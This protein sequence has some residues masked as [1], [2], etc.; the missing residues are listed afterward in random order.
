MIWMF[1]SL[2][3]SALKTGMQASADQRM[4]GIQ[5]DAIKAYNKQVV[6]ASAKSLNEINI[7]RSVSRQQTGQALDG[8]RRQAQQDKAQ[9][10]LQAAASDTMGASVDANIRDVDVQL[11]QAEST[12][13]R[14]QSLQEL[15][16]NSAVQQ[17]TD[18]SLN[19]LKDVQTGAGKDAWNAFLGS[20]VGTI[21][22]SMIGN[23]LS[24]NGWMGGEQKAAPISAAKGTVTPATRGLSDLFG[25]T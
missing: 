16:F 18:S 25:L 5:N 15:S 24:G 20:A 10:G 23:K 2:A 13:E 3:A 8:M 11:S 21:G 7:Q 22:T 1:A 14:N 12:L 17:S 4:Q 6:A 19:Q 9:R